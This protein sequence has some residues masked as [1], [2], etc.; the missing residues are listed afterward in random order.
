MYTV[1]INNKLHLCSVF[2][3]AAKSS[4]DLSHKTNSM[5]FRALSNVHFKLIVPV[6]YGLGG[7]WFSVSCIWFNKHQKVGNCEIWNNKT[8]S[9][10]KEAW[11]F[12]YTDENIKRNKRRLYVSIQLKV[13]RGTFQA[14]FYLE[15]NYSCQTVSILLL[16]HQHKML[17]PLNMVLL[18]EK[19]K[20]VFCWPSSPRWLEEMFQ[21]RRNWN[22]I[23]ILWINSADW[24]CYLHCI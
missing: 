15:T 24:I 6:G 5:R 22:K 2:D 10:L 23:Y 7:F 14:I 12:W 16:F 17:C 19:S 20:N 21:F 18:F 11:G 13:R 8:L 4:N 1:A 3:S 9:N